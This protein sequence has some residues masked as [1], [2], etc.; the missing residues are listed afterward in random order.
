ML[1]N[2]RFIVKMLGIMFILETFFMLLASVVAFVYDEGDFQ[3]LLLSAG[4]LFFSGLACYGIGFRANERNVGRREGM[5]I[6]TFT[7][8]LFS[9][10]GMLPF[11]LGGY[12]D[13]ITDAYFE[14]MSGFTTTGSSILTNIEA[15]PKGILFW[16]S[17]TQ[18][19]G[20][21]GMV[22]FT[23]AL[24]PIIGGGAS[25]MFEAES[26]GFVK[27]R[28]LP[29]ITQVAK[30][31]WGVYVTL[32]IAAILLLWAGPMDLFDAINHAFTA[33]STGG[34]S[35]KN[36]GVL[37]WDSA[38]IDYILSL[39][40][41]IGAT[42]MTLVYFCFKGQVKKLVCDEEFRF[43]FFFVVFVIL[44]STAWILHIGYVDNFLT[45]L[46]KATF[47]VVTIVSTC[48]YAAD[49]YIQW[50]PFFWFVVIILMLV[51]GCGGSTSGGIK[52]GRVVILTKVLFNQFKKQ[53]HPHAIVPI[54]MN[55]RVVSSEVVHRIM[56][57]VFVYLVLIIAG[58]FLFA[59]D[60]MGFEESVGMTISALGNVG[61]ALGSLGPVDN[62]SAIPDFSKWLM[63]FLMLVGRLELFTV[64]T[65]LLPSF[66]KQ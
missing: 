33:I 23:V 7:W 26:S 53:T 61:P 29:R 2:I 19:Q 57:F 43:F 48:G 41:F 56:A 31:I 14:T 22:V 42:N 44:V 13:N 65:I 9:F 5:L 27:D 15:L 66:W 59:L 20:G 60:G 8:I 25:L 35:T 54:R 58:C 11:Y 34:Y 12:I 38:Y 21:M 63:C 52:A 32:T 49:D 24:L 1:L 30:R 28:F 18:W 62:F 16:R 50:G 45:A 4:I 39:F 40:M 17:L 47:Q 6:V 64:L 37:Y 55:G 51:C 46:R 3:P 10:F 36:A